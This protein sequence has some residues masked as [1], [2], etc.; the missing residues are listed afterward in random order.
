M[1]ERTYHR[2]VLK[3]PTDETPAPRRISWKRILFV[4]VIVGVVILFGVA[5]R[6]PNLQITTVSV[7]GGEVIDAEEVSA[8]VKSLLAGRVLWIFPRSST[9]LIQTDTLEQEIREQFPRIA[10]IAIDRDNTQGLIV[11]I[12]EY[13]EAFLWCDGDDTCFFMDRNGVVYSPAPVFSGTAYSKIFSGIPRAPLPFEGMTP[14][15]LTLVKT[16]EQGLETLGITPSVFRFVSAQEVRVDFLHNKD[17]AQF[18]VDPTTPVETSLEY[19]I[20]GIRT[21]PLA[22]L[23]HDETKKLLYIDVRFPNNIVYKFE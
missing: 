13:Q 22:S 15:A 16:L 2:Q 12:T 5:V 1:Y 14:Q 21:E 3:T 18:I 4:I 6:H 23:F 10:T 17:I 7:E 11:R 8:R 9:L 19:L 20:S